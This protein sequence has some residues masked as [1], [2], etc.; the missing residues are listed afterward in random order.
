[1]K[2][3]SIVLLTVATLSF[4]GCNKTCTINSTFQV[5]TPV[6]QKW[7]EIRNS[8][9]S[10]QPQPIRNIG[11]M[12]ILGNRLYLV[13][14]DKGIHVAD[15]TNIGQPVF[16]AFIKVPGCRQLSVRGTTLFADSY[17]DLLTIDASSPLQASI[18]KRDKDVYPF[19]QYEGGFADDA[20]KGAIVSWAKKDTTI[21]EDCSHPNNSSFTTKNANGQ[22]QAFVQ[23]SNSITSNLAD[24]SG[25]GYQ[26]PQAISSSYSRSASIGDYIYSLVNHELYVFHQTGGLKTKINLNNNNVETLQAANGNLF[27]GSETGMCIYDCSSPENPKKAGDFEHVQSKDPVVV[28]GNNAFVTTRRDNGSGFNE[29]NVVDITNIYFPKQKASSTLTGPYGL[30]VSEGNIYICDGTAGLHLYSYQNSILTKVKNINTT[31]SYDIIYYNNALLVKGG[32]GLYYYNATQK[33][34]PQIVGK[35]LFAK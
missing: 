25:T 21:I 4:W 7:D 13:E 20:T 19:H 6:Y 30:A 18:I 32:D 17:V 11:D 3:I 26:G 12:V 33:N 15:N 24:L 34:N 14:S 10:T 1:M 8:F 2:K 22:P 28:E 35:T 16:L 31:P 27:M 23:N 9:G 29:L 5:Y